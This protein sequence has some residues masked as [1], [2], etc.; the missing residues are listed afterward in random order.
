MSN[1]AKIIL[2]VFRKC[3]ISEKTSGGGG[4]GG[5]GGGWGWIHH[6]KVSGDRQTKI[7]QTGNNI[8]NDKDEMFILS[9]GW[10]KDSN[11]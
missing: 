9:R 5:G 2:A 6:C 8:I 10:D 4:G 3:V 11:P 1:S 7:I